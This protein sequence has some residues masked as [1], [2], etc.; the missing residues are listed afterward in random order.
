MWLI[1]GALQEDF[2]FD[3]I[4]P[5]NGYGDQ[6]AFVAKVSADGSS[7]LWATFIGSAAP[8]LMRDLRVDAVH[9]VVHCGANRVAGSGAPSSSGWTRGLRAARPMP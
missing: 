3:T 9:G 5:T 8:T 6:D 2:I 4:Q 7:L 1:P